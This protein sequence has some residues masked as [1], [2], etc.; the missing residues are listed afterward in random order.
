MLAASCATPRGPFQT[1]AVSDRCASFSGAL[2]IHVAPRGMCSLTFPHCH[3]ALLSLCLLRSG[4]PQ[5]DFEL[6]KV[7]LPTLRLLLQMEDEETLADS[8]WALCYL[9]NDRTED[10]SH[11]RAVIQSDVTPRLVE[12]LRNANKR[13]VTAA[14]HTVRTTPHL[15]MQ[16]DTVHALLLTSCA[17]VALL[18]LC[19]LAI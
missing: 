15:S 11:I 9:S 12:L 14:I 4:H 7:A 19:R 5:P 18:L 16:P 17:L 1:S 13:I 6:V 3:C 8:C 10:H 2:L